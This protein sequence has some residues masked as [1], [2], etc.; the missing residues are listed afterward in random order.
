MT[1]RHELESKFETSLKFQLFPGSV[2][3]SRKTCSLTDLS[4]EFLS[5]SVSFTI[6]CYHCLCLHKK[7]VSIAH[8]AHSE[9]IGSIVSICIDFLTLAVRLSPRRKEF[10]ECNAGFRRNG[11][12]DI[13]IISTEDDVFSHEFDMLTRIQNCS[14]AALVL[15]VISS[16]KAIGRLEISPCVVQTP[17][18]L[19]ERHAMEFRS[20]N[21]ISKEG[22]QIL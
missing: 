18:V 3:G 10:S 22:E 13:I 2:V 7:D 21:G 11:S 5:C 4:E 15:F 1:A 6:H 17:S 12:I 8:Q 9:S 14:I 19:I 20:V 16:P